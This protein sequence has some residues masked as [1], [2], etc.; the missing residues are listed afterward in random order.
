MFRAFLADTFPSLAAAM[1]AGTR[2]CWYCD[3]FDG[4]FWIG[5][6]PQ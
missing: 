5:H 4:H 2:Q 1:I 3:T 6:H